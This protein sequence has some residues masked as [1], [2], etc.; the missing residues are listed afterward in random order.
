MTQFKLISSN[1]LDL[2]EER[3][4]EFTRALPQDAV[5]VNI[6]FSTTAFSSTVEYSALVQYKQTESWD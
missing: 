5:I 2:F 3:I 1:S 4:N 6:N